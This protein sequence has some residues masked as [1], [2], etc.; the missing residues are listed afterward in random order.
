MSVCD[1]VFGC[2]SLQDVELGK[3]YWKILNSWGKNFGEGGFIRLLR[4]DQEDCLDPECVTVCE[5]RVR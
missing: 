2:S 5:R 4:T 3:K 1:G